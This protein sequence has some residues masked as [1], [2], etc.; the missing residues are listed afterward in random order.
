MAVVN[1]RSSIFKIS[2][3]VATSR[4][5]SCYVDSVDGLLPDM[6]TEEITTFCNT[7]VA[8]AATIQQAT[9]FT[10][11]GPFDTTA[12]TGPDAVLAPLW[13]AGTPTPFEYAPAGIGTGNRKFSGNGI[14]TQY[15]VTS[16]A[17]SVVRYTASILPTGGVAVGVY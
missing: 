7:G 16:T 12:T 11:G 2:D 9:A 13:V 15:K 17:G 3:V 5:L 6:G 10:I 8:S 4:D 14:V 1:S